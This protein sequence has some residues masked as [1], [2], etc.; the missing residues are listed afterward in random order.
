VDGGSESLRPLEVAGQ[1]RLATQEAQRPADELGAR[2]LEHADVVVEV[3]AAVEQALHGDGAGQVV[4]QD[5]PGDGAVEVVVAR[6]SARG[7]LRPRGWRVAARGPDQHTR[8]QEDGDEVRK[9]HLI[10]IKAVPAHS[11]GAGA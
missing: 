2:A 4:L 10:P 3:A 6:G 1:V 11:P 8:R 9:G 7:G 5:L